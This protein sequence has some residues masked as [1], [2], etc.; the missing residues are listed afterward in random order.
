MKTEGKWNGQVEEEGTRMVEGGRGLEA[1]GG[2]PLLQK[3]LIK[4]TFTS[5]YS[6]PAVKLHYSRFLFKPVVMQLIAAGLYY[7]P[8]VMS[9]SNNTVS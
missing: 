8:T 3:G 5:V 1:L 2:Q 7:Q 4:R 9:A 6:E